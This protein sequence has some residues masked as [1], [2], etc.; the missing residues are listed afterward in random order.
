MWC[1][2]S[3]CKEDIGSLHRVF[4]ANKAVQKSFW[5]IVYSM[6]EVMLLLNYINFGKYALQ[7]F[8]WNMKQVKRKENDEVVIRLLVMFIL[9]IH[10]QYLS[11]TIYNIGCSITWHAQCVQTWENERTYKHIRIDFLEIN[12][13]GDFFSWGRKQIFFGLSFVSHLSSLC[14]FFP[15]FLCLS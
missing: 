7:R 11:K 14:F 13:R 12:L 3:M 2:I 15:P 5:R 9:Y 1:K 6:R 10:C 4:E 8:N